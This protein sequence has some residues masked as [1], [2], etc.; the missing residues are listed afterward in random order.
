M[1]SNASQATQ[2]R[3][4]PT[5]RAA[6]ADAIK[7]LKA[8]HAEVKKLFAQYAKMAKA[9]QDA[10]ERSALAN[11]ICDKLTVHTK[12]EEEIFYP[13]AREALGGNSDLVDEAD[14]E[15]A[16]AKEL[17]AQIREGNP[18]DDHYD[19]KVTVL[20]E[21]VDHHVKEEQDQ[22]FPKIKSKL[23]LQALGEQLQA[24]KE[25]LLGE[26]SAAH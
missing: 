26:L 15:H 23:D 3:A 25:E 13:A 2:T 5:R 7:L 1:P 21:Y 24:R 18:E 19:A 4:T 14:V 20:G 6:K 9:E 11:D 8:D 10:S 12:I 22:M 17:I 16:S